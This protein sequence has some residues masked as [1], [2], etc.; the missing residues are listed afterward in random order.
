MEEVRLKSTKSH[1]VGRGWLPFFG[2]KV[3]EL[4]TGREA[5]LED[6]PRQGLKESGS[7]ANTGKVGAAPEV[8]GWEEEDDGPKEEGWAVAEKED[9][10]RGEGCD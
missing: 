7:V 6:G 10:D 9:D 8:A 3:E 1:R 5:I 2:K 4:L